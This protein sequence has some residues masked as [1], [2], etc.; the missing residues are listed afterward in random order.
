MQQLT[1]LFK[2]GINF[3]LFSP[4]MASLEFLFP[5]RYVAGPRSRFTVC[6]ASVFFFQPEFMRFVVFE[7]CVEQLQALTLIFDLEAAQSYNQFSSTCLVL[8][9]CS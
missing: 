7:A 2:K 9:C 4:S 6:T 1:L 5:R 3:W 8:P